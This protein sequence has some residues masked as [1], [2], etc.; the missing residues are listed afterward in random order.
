M[1]NLIEQ[2]ET[3]LIE[4]KIKQE[5]GID[6][7]NHKQA[8]NKINKSSNKNS[9]DINDQNELD[10]DDELENNEFNKS[11]EASIE[12]NSN[13][14]II[15]LSFKFLNLLLICIQLN[16]KTNKRSNEEVNEEGFIEEEESDGEVKSVLNTDNDL[17]DGEVVR[18][19]VIIKKFDKLCF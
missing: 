5:D 19:L 15:V 17:D 16:I 6:E 13:D 9:F 10:Y 8:I 3:T 1:S 7:N 14:V 12:I 11:K 2:N 18:I 4:V